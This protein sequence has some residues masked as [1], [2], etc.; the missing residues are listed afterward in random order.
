M[1]GY[2]T[3]EGAFISA[4]SE[5][6]SLLNARTLGAAAVATAASWAGAKWAT[7]RNKRNP[8]ESPIE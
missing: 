2:F 6:G 8:E 1:S 4:N 5:H 3:L 7:H